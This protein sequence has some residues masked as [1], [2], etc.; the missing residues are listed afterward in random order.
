MNIF[1]FKP[2]PRVEQRYSQFNWWC[3]RCAIYSCLQ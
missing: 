1:K 2:F 3:K